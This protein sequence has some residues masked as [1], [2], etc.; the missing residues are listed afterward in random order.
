[1][2]KGTYNIFNVEVGRVILVPLNPHESP[3]GE[4]GV[5][6]A[7]ISIPSSSSMSGLG[8]NYK[9]GGRITKLFSKQDKTSFFH[10]LGH[11]CGLR[12][13]NMHPGCPADVAAEDS[14]ARNEAKVGYQ[15]PSVIELTEY[16]QLSIMLY[17]KNKNSALSELDKVGLRKLFDT[18]PPS[19]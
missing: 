13:E 4:T 10:E 19:S 11:L 7:K 12:H 9:G 17:G 18:L 16:D 1:M 8:Q 3:E 6:Y 15:R 14:S 5:R 2:G